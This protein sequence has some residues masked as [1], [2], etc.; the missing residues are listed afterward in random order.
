[1]DALQLIDT[2][3]YNESEIDRIARVAFNAAMGRSKRLTSIDKA[4]V[5]R[6][7]MLEEYV[8][9]NYISQD[10]PE[11][12]KSR[13]EYIKIL[14]KNFPKNFTLKGMKIVIDC[15][16]GASYKSGPT[17]LKKLGAELIEVEAV[18]YISSNPIFR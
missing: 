14:L 3:I 8:K 2:M 5:L 13:N 9:N 6:N 12:Q 11:H 7:G 15:A 16:N 18:P 10:G 1:M 4:N 17:L